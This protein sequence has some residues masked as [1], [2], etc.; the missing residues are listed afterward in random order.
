DGETECTVLLPRRLLNRRWQWLLHGRTADRI[1]GAVEAVPHVAATIVPYSAAASPAP[2]EHRGALIPMPG[3]PHRPRHRAAPPD[4]DQ[5]LAKR[6]AGAT[7]INDVVWRRRA[8][9]AGRI[10][11]LRVQTARSS[12]NLECVL[13][14]G[15]GDLLLVFQGRPQIPGIVPGARLV[16]EG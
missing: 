1:A 12:S 7:P 5:A 9:V 4:V 16:A 3:H 13:T 2:P 10:R 14:D 15:T 8:V 6:A 11:Q